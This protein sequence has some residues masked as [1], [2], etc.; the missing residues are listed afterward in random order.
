MPEAIAILTELLKCKTPL[1]CPSGNRAIVK[2]EE[3][4]LEGWFKLQSKDQ[5]FTEESE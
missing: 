2:V 5:A 4:E 3:Y 1:F